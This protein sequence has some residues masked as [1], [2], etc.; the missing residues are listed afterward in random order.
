M[1]GD[2]LDKFTQDEWRRHHACNA[3]ERWIHGFEHWRLRAT[4]QRSARL[5]SQTL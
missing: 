3:T 1:T 4:C 5:C 2:N